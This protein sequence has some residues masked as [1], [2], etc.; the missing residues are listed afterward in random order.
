MGCSLAAEEALGLVGVRK[1]SERRGVGR[2]FSVTLSASGVKLVKLP[3]KW[4]AKHLREEVNDLGM[5]LTD[6]P[7]CTTL[8]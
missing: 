8:R 5:L 4:E 1:V 3:T 2:H 6:L 7:A